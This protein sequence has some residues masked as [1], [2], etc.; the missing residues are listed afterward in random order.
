[1]SDDQSSRYYTYCVV[2]YSHDVAA[3]ERLNVG[4]V[5][6]SHEPRYLGWK[7]DCDARG[8]AKIFHGFNRSLHKKVLGQLED[9]LD[10]IKTQPMLFP[11]NSATD[12]LRQIWPDR[13][14]RYTW[15]DAKPGVYGHESQ[16]PGE[17]EALYAAFIGKQ[18]PTN[19]LSSTRTDAN[20]MGQLRR[21]LQ[22]KVDFRMLK[23]VGL[24]VG[25]VEFKFDFT[26]RN[27]SLNIFEP[28]SLDLSGADEIRDK[29]LRYLGYG[30]VLAEA[31]QARFLFALG[32]PQDPSCAQAYETAKGWLAAMRAPSQ[33]F[34]EDQ[35][36][37]IGDA[38]RR[39]MD[40]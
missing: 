9:A 37:E 11:V 3:G 4:V 26:H 28:I 22:Q 25:P 33:V 8:F 6:F 15:Q 7:L 29:T 23:P 36:D 35:V 19:Q 34:D 10:R 31:H 27:G 21:E 24:N 5:L 13:G 32:R 38:L 17:V 30:D 18:R 2:S 14:F 39:I 40:S 12:L 20:V 16:L 1:M